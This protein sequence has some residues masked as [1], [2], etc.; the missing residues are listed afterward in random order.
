[1]SELSTPWRRA[2]PV[3]A[4]ALLTVAG[5]AAAATAAADPLG[6]SGAAKGAPAATPVT[7]PDAGCTLSPSLNLKSETASCIGVG[8]TLS[9]V[10]ALGGTATL[11]VT[12]KTGRAEKATNVTVDLPSTLA[13]ADGTATRA[14]V[15]G[16]GRSAR[17]TIAT[18]D[19]AKGETR[20]WTR[21]VKAVA[22]GAGEIKASALSRV[23]AGRTDGG[24]D[25]VH[26]TVGA[27]GAASKAGITPVSGNQATVA[28]SARAAAP[29]VNRPNVPLPAAKGASAATAKAPGTACA[30]GS[31][32]FVDQA[33][34]TRGVGKVVVQVWESG[35]GQLASGYAGGT[36]GYTVCFGTGGATKTVYVRFVLTNPVWEVV[37]N[38]GNDYAWA[39]GAVAVPDNTT[40]DFGS[41]QPADST[42]MRANHA[43]YDYSFMYDWI[44]QNSGTATTGCWS[45][46]ASSCYQLVVHWQSDSTDGTYFN[47]GT[48][49]HLLA[50]SPD[51][52]DEP[53]HEAGHALMY[54]LYGNTFP[55]TTNCS[56]HYLFTISSTTCGFTEGWADWVDTSVWNNTTY[57]F[58]SLAT[59][60]FNVTWGAGG[61][62]GD[63]V[64][65]RIV[66]ALDSINDGVKYP[67]D[68][69]SGPGYNHATDYFNVLRTY[70]P[71]TFAAFWSGRGALGQDVG[72]AS[73]SALFQGTIDYGFR[74][75]LTDGVSKTM[76]VAIVPH[77]YS[78]TTTRGYWSAVAVRP[79][80][81]SDSDLALYNDY[82]Q[83][84]V[85]GTSSYGGTTTDF[86]AVNSNSGAR[87][88]Q[89]YYPR[90]TAFTGTGNYTVEYVQGNTTFSLGT[91]TIATDSTLPI[92][93]MDS[94]QNTGV[95]VYYRAVPAAGQSIGLTFLQPGQTVLGRSS[96][97]SSAIGASGQA[98]A[99]AATPAATGYGALV[100]T[101][102]GLSS[103]SVALYAD[104][105]APTGSVTIASGAATTTK[106]NVPVQLSATDAE[107]GVVSMQISTDGTFDTEP[108]VPY[109]TSAV[110][111]LTGINGIKTVYVRYL[112]NA[113]MWSDPV[114]DTID[115]EVVPTATTVS[116][117]KGPA[118][119]GTSV[120]IHGTRF[121][122]ATAVKFGGIEAPTFTVLN[123]NV[124]R[125][126][127]PAGSGT[128][129]LSVTVPAGTAAST[130]TFTYI[131]A[132]VVTSVSPNQGTTGTV[133]TV[134]GSNFTGATRV[135]FGTV[136]GTNL[137]I[138]NANQLRITAPAGSPGVVNI[139]VTT[140]G[141][142]SAIVTADRFTYVAAPAVTSVTPNAGPAGTV[143]TIRGTN[144]TGTTRVQFANTS[145]TNVTVVNATTVRATAPAGTGLVNVRV[146]TPGGASPI[147]TADR[148]TYTA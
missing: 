122:G 146:T 5:L 11:T 29:V 18:V 108:V 61:D 21:T 79:A 135:Q 94:Y 20:T 57:T 124:I 58:A 95:P 19:L 102:Q 103:G 144:L 8:A 110:A 49:V 26:L 115:L 99:V 109:A 143:V 89:T 27:A 42:T 82:A 100:V 140:P 31:W 116:P 113:G 43:Y 98:V 3:A 105:S 34:V 114:S 9:K 13:F 96:G 83:T 46:Y 45:P 127:S 52:E 81:G 12:V 86:V 51:S 137:V 145:A 80:D 112:N 75:P 59:A 101:N 71:S 64:E 141:G 78:A 1:M 70:Q 66:Q 84:Q 106:T 55:T 74:N 123:D 35:G 41:L 44:Y 120:L 93:I 56:P 125:A 63:Q 73:L 129:H 121:T 14:A 15:T 76:P 117:V 4:L 36:G 30:T 25:Y 22:P 50:A 24:A 142:A 87:P 119:G 130:G 16:A 68:N 48:G 134:N 17:G 85:L 97:V 37:T 69:I 88:L 133:V 128:V 7:H 91:T 139:R 104:I 2:V 65:G 62:N 111:K 23:D 47:T 126:T 28:T 67:F 131:P 32:N 40:H 38:A 107:T 60:E 6:A 92:A 72:Q 53:V 10:P 136:T 118:G 148:F 138:V 33:G 39:T 54:G 147:T 132:P 90:V 77:N